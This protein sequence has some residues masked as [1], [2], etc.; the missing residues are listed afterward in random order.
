MTPSNAERSPRIGTDIR[1]IEGTTLWGQG[2]ELLDAVAAQ[3][4]DGVNIRTLYEL[5][6]TLDRGRL[7]EFA[8]HADALGLYV[9]MGIGRVNPFN[10]AELPA[11]R[12]LGQGDYLAAMTRM[13]EICADRGWHTLWTACGGF[14][15]FPGIHATDRYRTDADWSEQ[16]RITEAFL[17][18]LAPV[19]RANGCRLAV[20]TH[21]EITSHEVVRL[22]E[23]AGPDAVGICLDPGNLPLNGEDPMAGIRRVA[24]YVVSTQLRDVALWPRVGEISRFL[25]PCGEGVLD[26]TEV[27]R[28][29]LDTT[30]D[31]NLTIEGIGGTRAELRVPCTDTAW[32]AGQPDLD[33]AEIAVLQQLATDYRKRAEAGTA[34]GLDLLELHSDTWRAAHDDFVYTSAAHL[35]AC[36]AALA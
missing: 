22:V 21:E 32:L 29:L 23:A 16:L 26:W 10:T 31:L 28:L 14:T 4:L 17:R 20:E 15:F 35:R 1:H 2:P 24:P 8:S 18:K 9:E 11:V 34:P 33:P 5:S 25:A 6:P 7:A 30:P 19:L 36:V 3:G 27:L 12:A 13:V